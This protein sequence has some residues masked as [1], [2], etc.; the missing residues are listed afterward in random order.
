[1]GWKPYFVQADSAGDSAGT[2]G[3]DKLR[4]LLSAARLLLMTCPHRLGQ[5]EDS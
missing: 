2:S 1:M 3:V 4:K 5:F